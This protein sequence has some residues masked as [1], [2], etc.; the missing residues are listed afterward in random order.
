VTTVTDPS[1]RPVSP[2]AG[3]A[4]EPVSTGIVEAPDGVRIAFDVYGSGAP[5]LVLLPSTPIVH[6][7]QWKGQV[8]FLS[9]HYRVVTFDGRGNGRS[10]RPVQP[11][12]YTDARLI[13]D[14]VA[15]MDATDTPRAVLVGLCGDGVWRA[16][17]TPIG[18]TGSSPSRSAS[19]GCRRSTSIE[20]QC[21]STTSCPRTTAG[22]K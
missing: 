22:R 5:T 7:R 2:D 21:G 6:S 3:R 9:R 4:I 13:G 15:V 16:I 17:R 18:F 10:D 1:S 14:I 11:E 8:P 12:A 20:P 19:H